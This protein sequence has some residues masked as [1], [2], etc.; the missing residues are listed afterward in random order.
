[1]SNDPRVVTIVQINR[2]RAKFSALPAQT[3]GLK[4]GQT[5]SVEFPDD[6]QRMSATVE[7]LSPVI[8][9]K[10]GTLLVTLAL[11]NQNEQLT[12]GAR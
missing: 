12:S 8:D 10:S 3:R 11:E 7:S 4:I 6:A 2:L 9:A 1:M 5:V